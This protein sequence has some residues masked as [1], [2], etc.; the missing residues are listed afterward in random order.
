MN[1]SSW[2]DHTFDNYQEVAKDDVPAVQRGILNFTGGLT[3]TDNPA[4]GS[5]D[6]ALSGV[7]AL[8]QSTFGINGRVIS[9]VV[10][11][12]TT[13]DNPVDAVLYTLAPD[14]RADVRVT[15]WAGSDTS[16][17]VFLCD[18]RRQ[19]GR[20]G[21]SAAAACTGDVNENDV[22]IP[23]NDNNFQVV[24]SGNNVIGEYNGT[25]TE[26]QNWIIT[27]TITVVKKGGT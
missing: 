17:G 2:L 13:D 8:D 11:G 22:K 6:V 1:G 27:A 14:E 23:L 4:T 24:F 18:A 5:T 16:N 3:V 25:G 10:E 15:A 9:K 12:A 19:I 7:L 21:T 26:H 20:N